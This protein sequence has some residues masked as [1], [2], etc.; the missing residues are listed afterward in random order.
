MKKVVFLDPVDPVVLQTLESSGF[1]CHPYDGKMPAEK[2]VKSCCGIIVRSRTPIDKALL[3]A[4][5][6]L[7]FVGRLGAGMENIDTL[8]AQKKGV[9][10]FNSPEG[11]RDAVGEHALGMLLAMMNHIPRAHE[12]VIQGIWQREENRGEEIKGKT[13]GIVGYGNTGSA[14]AKKLQGLECHVLAYDKYK[15]GFGSSLVEEVTS[16]Q[17]FRETDILSLHIPLTPETRYMVNSQYLESFHKPIRLINTAR[18]K[19]VDTHALLES[20]R[21]EKVRQAALDVLEFE[22]PSFE[23]LHF[24]E[25]PQVFQ[26]L[27]QTGKVLLSPHIAGWTRESKYKLGKV[28]AEKILNHYR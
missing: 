18:G 1:K 20:I 10:V 2:M 11:N 4:A 13:I 22:S 16:E 23:R 27:C 3:D 7:E 19:I 26:D 5:E 28:L 12:Q 24:N 21:R 8:Y 15:T 25:L 17:I 9:A 6:N 14:F